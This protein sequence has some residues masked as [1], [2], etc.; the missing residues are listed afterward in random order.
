[1]LVLAGKIRNE[2]TGLK[3]DAEMLFHPEL[4]IKKDDTDKKQVYAQHHFRMR[5]NGFPG[6]F[7]LLTPMNIV[8]YQDG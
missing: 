2:G 7:H 6:T 4:W 3:P 8:E 1:M 5:A